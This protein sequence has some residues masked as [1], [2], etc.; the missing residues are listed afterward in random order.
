[1]YRVS[2]ALPQAVYLPKSQPCALKIIALEVRLPLL[3]VSVLNPLLLQED[4]SFDDLVSGASSAC[5]CGRD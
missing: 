3:V 2:D 4:E 5:V 1:M